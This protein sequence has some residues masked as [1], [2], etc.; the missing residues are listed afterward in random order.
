MEDQKG[1]TISG[2]GH[3]S[4]YICE[5]SKPFKDKTAMPE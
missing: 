2:S 4:D 3:W 5:D 1:Q